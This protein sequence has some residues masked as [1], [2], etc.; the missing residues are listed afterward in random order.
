MF[1]YTEEMEQHTTLGTGELAGWLDALPTLPSDVPD[2]ERIDRIR[3][4]EDLKGAI[5]AAQAREAVALKQ[6]VIAAETRAGVPAHKRGRGVAA[7]LAL[8]RRESPHHGDRLMGLA[9]ALV[10][11]LPHT[12][13]ALTR[14]QISEWRA[15]LVCRETAWLTVEHR[16][17]VDAQIAEDLASMSARQ[18]AATARRIGYRL[19]PHSIVNRAARA[20]TDRRV[21]IRPAPDTMTLLTAL[22]PVAQ[23]VA[24]YAALSQAADTARASGD[25]RSRGQIMADTLVTRTTGQ[26]RADQTP[27]EIQL[28]MTDQTLFGDGETPAEIPGHGPIPAPIARQ[29]IASLEP[30]TRLSLRRLYAHPGTGRLVAMESSRRR[31][32]KSLRRY[33]AVRDQY[34]RTPWCGA[35]IRHIDHTRPHHAGG[36]TSIANG[37]GLCERCNQIKEAP[38][39]HSTPTPDG[40]VIT[41]TP[42][43]HHYS[44]QAPP[45][46]TPT[47]LRPH[48]VDLYFVGQLARAA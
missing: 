17:H 24:A 3:M 33:L 47:P 9:E 8:A 4:L 37:Q 43:G 34:C 7:Q 38:G 18:V 48:R 39:W 23:G 11:E 10:R 46:T 27:V 40:T 22:L 36:S 2:A 31:F 44:S 5:C 6:S 25:P 1:D 14:G 32:P 15:T 30:A 42:T 12:M 29:L 41:T 20:V 28:L 21:T 45:L 13:A 16:R 26:T 35:P 19:D